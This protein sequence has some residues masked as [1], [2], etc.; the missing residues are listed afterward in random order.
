M[1]AA[2]KSGN[3]LVTPEDVHKAAAAI[4]GEIRR[5]PCDV[6]RTLSAIAG[7]ELI[8]KFEN[9][10]FTAAFKER[11]AL[12]FL[13]QLS[14][15]ERQRGV[16]AMSA[17]NHAQG[18]AYHA[19]RLGIPAKIVMPEG[20]P[21]V[22]IEN[23]A[24]LGAEV[25]VHGS[26]LEEA[27]EHAEQIAEAE[28]RVFV[29]PFDEPLVIAGQGTIALEM[30]ED[31]PDIEVLVIPIGGGGLISGMATAA[32]SLNPDI[33]IVG[34]QAELFPSMLAAIKGVEME[35]GGDSLAEGIAVKYPG[36]ITQTI[37]R[38]LVDDIVTVTEDDLEHGVS[39]LLNVEK[40][41]AE[42]AGAAG[43][44]AVL[45]YPERFKERKVGLVICGGNIDPRLLSAILV[46]DLIREG[47]LARLRVR[48]RDIPGQLVKIAKT[49]ADHG[50]NIIDVNHH[51]LHTNLPAKGT[52][53]DLD[54][55]TRD[56]ERLQHI[57]EDLQSQGFEVKKLG[58][59]I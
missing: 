46:R 8:L 30:L 31:F 11:G 34:V 29:H 42:G 9:L 40:T 24:V 54:V 13:L 48:M 41:V 4:A 20:T 39:M 10:Q 52:F 43:L 1:D 27:T 5:T 51:R 19:T 23:T 35:C 7:C 56:E 2:A 47:R 36:A 22:K 37:V 33:E 15:E 32:R 38:D 53:C 18:V 6:S 55:E 21:L 50:G 44:S 3:T 14:E 59:E 16:V 49:I 45:A 57:V 28:N 26:V 58:A 17:G 25:I 12:N